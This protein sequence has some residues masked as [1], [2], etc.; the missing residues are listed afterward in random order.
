MTEPG[1][2]FRKV[3]KTWPDG[4]V[5]IRELDLEIEK[6]ELC[7]I[8]GESGSGKSTTL[9]L[10]NRL[11]GPTRGTVLVEGK[12]VA[13]LDPIALRRSIGTVFQRFALFP[14]MSV[15]DNIAIVPSL[16]GWDRARTEKRVDELLELTGLDPA[17]YRDRSPRELSGGQQQRVGIARALAARPG[18]VL[19]D[20]PFGALDPVTRD[21]LGSEVRRLHVELGLTT[22]LVTHDM[23]EALLLGDR[24]AVMHSG[25]LLQYGTPRELS[26]S[27]ADP[28]VEE[29]LSTPRR[30]AEKLRQA[31]GAEP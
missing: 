8:V 30:Q 3:N 9:R 12:D 24:V 7:A 15:A 28:R 10:V 25:E 20:E 31:L 6:G 23:T 29:L 26:E 22:L 13:S 2:A 4:S 21:A 1:I 11:V 5:A 27:P 19:M 14:H 17:T 16:L 18:I